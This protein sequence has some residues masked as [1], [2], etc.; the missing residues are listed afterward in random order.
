MLRR[1]IKA[2]RRELVDHLIIEEFKESKY[3]PL[4]FINEPFQSPVIENHL[5]ITDLFDQV[6]TTQ[7]NDKDVT[8][9]SPNKYKVYVADTP[10]CIKGLTCI[11]RRM[12]G[13]NL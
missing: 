7:M 6:N 13:L 11:E 12:K 9:L 1:E 2:N 3:K 5:K 4:K 10:D 8:I